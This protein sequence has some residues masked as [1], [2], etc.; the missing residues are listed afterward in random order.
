MT[1]FSDNPGLER[2]MTQKPTGGRVR[3]GNP[4][5]AQ[6]SPSPHSREGRGRRSVGSCYRDRMHGRRKKH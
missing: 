3:R 4:S 6:E 5:A 2:M 1:L